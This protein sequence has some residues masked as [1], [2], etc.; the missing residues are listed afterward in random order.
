MNERTHCSC[1]DIGI[2]T[3]RDACAHG[4]HSVKTCFKSIGC[5][6][7]CNNCIPMVR[8]VLTEFAQQTPPAQE[9]VGTFPIAINASHQ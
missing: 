1:H 5:M 8:S 9:Q 3:F 2:E 4:A 6:P 7:K